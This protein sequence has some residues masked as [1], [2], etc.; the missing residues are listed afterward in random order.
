MTMRERERESDT[1]K[2]TNHLGKVI[3]KHRAQY[4]CQGKNPA[5]QESRKM[6]TI[7]PTGYSHQSRLKTY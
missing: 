7:R 2:V 5:K 1:G 4:G 6:P 3:D